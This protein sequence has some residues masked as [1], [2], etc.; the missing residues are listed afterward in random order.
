MDSADS[1]EKHVQDT[2]M[3]GAGLCDESVVRT[4]IEEGPQQIRHLVDGGATFSSQ[5]GKLHLAGR[6]DTRLIA[7]YTLQM[8]RVKSSSFLCW[9]A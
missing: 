1:I 9:I 4:N 5:S 7:S 3:A 8:R 2:L 6:V